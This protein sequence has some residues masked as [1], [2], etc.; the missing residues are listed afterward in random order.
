[1]CNKCHLFFVMWKHWYLVVS[2]RSIKKRQ[3]SMPGCGI[4]YLIYLEQWEAIFQADFIHIHVVCAHLP[5]FPFLGTTTT[6]VN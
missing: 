4:D 5:F 1:M 2:K 3:H 6:F